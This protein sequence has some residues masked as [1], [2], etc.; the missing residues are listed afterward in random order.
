[1]LEAAS[2]AMD[3]GYEVALRYA[4]KYVFS[5]FVSE[6]FDAS[7]GSY[8]S[9]YTAL[10]ERSYELDLNSLTQRQARIVESFVHR[11][12]VAVVQRD[13]GAGG[14]VPG[15]NRQVSLLIVDPARQASAQQINLGEY[16][17]VTSVTASEDYVLVA[18]Q[19]ELPNG[20]LQSK[21]TV[22]EFTNPSTPRYSVVGED[23]RLFAGTEHFRVVN[24]GDSMAV[25]SQA[26]GIVIFR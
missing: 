14:A 2:F 7:N 26:G 17:F 22:V 20:N 6:I 24:G 10:Q 13:V 12:R 15:D 8:E 4:L 19:T 21:A 18:G 11:D 5:R 1:M 9:W 16:R 25:L 23:A 3:V